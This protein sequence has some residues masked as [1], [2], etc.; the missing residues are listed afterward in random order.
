[1]PKKIALLTGWVT[2]GTAGKTVDG[3]V[4]EAAWLEQMAKS[5][6][7]EEYTAV[8]NSD[9]MLGW[10]GSFGQ[11]R[12]LRTAKDSKG[13]VIL[14][15]RLEPNQRL[16][17]MASYGQ[18]LFMS[19]EIHADYCDTG[20]AYLVG[21]AITDNPASVGTTELR[22]TKAAENKQYRAESV[23]LD[24][25]VLK[26]D[27][28]EAN[29]DLLTRL[30][31]ALTK[32]FSNQHEEK[33]DDAMN[34]EQLKALT[35]GQEKTTQALTGLTDLLTKH[36][37]GEKPAGDGNETPPPKAPTGDGDFTA[38]FKI[39]T[40]GQTKLSTDI[41]ALTSTLKTAIEGANGTKFVAGQGAAGDNTDD[42]I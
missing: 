17:D 1:M 36:F 23:E 29:T 18:R 30:C 9:H 21:L 22:F 20:E 35:D 4:I 13:R 3:R 12:A 5:Y 40:D 28:T 25:A 11:V 26:A 14:Q 42:V 41:E 37:K 16:L 15:A 31:S 7:C 38:K 8:I 27:D 33:E 2:V 24:T 39:L 6:S 10:Y 34:A 32:A 19:M